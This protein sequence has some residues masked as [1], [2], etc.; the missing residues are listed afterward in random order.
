MAVLTPSFPAR[1]GPAREPVAA[2]PLSPDPHR[3]TPM[4]RRRLGST[5]MVAS[6]LGFGG[7]EIGYC[8]SSVQ[9]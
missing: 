4:E 6:I 9:V 1:T 2:A 5:D 8:A 3:H 7:S